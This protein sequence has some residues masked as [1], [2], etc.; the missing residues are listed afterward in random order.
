[1]NLVARIKG[2]AYSGQIAS[3]FRGYTLGIRMVS[4]HQRAA[5]ARLHLPAFPAR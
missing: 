2:V 1:M 3:L 5:H 4:I